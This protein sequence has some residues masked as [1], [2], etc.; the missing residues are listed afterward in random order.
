MAV[1]VEGT[2]AGT[3]VVAMVVHAKT[4]MRAKVGNSILGID[5]SFAARAGTTRKYFVRI[6][7]IDVRA[8]FLIGSGFNRALA[9]HVGIQS[10]GSSLISL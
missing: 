2:F 3:T 6:F 10:F 8:A 4:A 7:V 5:G 9:L 1:F